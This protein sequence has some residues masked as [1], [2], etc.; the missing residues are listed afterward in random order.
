MKGDRVKT[1][2]F[3]RYAMFATLLLSLWVMSGGSALACPG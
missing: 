3:G 2:A 1:R